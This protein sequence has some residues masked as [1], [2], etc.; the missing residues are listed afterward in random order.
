MLPISPEEQAV[1]SYHLTQSARILYKNTE[2]ENFEKMEIVLR[3]QLLETLGST[4]GE[5][6]SAGGTQCSG[7]KR[8]VG[9]V[10]VSQKQARKLYY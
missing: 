1:L 5:F 10:T 9:E 3:E 7:N 6:F 4:I 2:Q 8:K